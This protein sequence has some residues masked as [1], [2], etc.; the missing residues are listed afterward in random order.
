MVMRQR[1]IPAAR[2]SPQ[3]PLG[4]GGATL[5]QAWEHGNKLRTQHPLTT[6]TPTAPKKTVT[7]RRFSM[8]RIR[9]ADQ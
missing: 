5:R 4:A 2:R 6:P 3:K 8:E 7:L 9:A 1:G